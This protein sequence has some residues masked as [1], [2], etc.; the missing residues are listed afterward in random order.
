MAKPPKFD[1]KKPWS[2][3]KSANARFI[4]Q[5]DNYF[6]Y[7][8]A[9]GPFIDSIMQRLL[10]PTPQFIMS[11]EDYEKKE[12]MDHYRLAKMRASKEVTELEI[13]EHE[14]R[15]DGVLE[16]RKVEGANA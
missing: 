8:E 7:A 10:L 5:D 14:L 15:R 3:M 4:V 1:Q 2:T 9:T 12:R 13:I 16:E 11:R 6:S